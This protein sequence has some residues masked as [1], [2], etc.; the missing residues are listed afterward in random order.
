MESIIVP[1][2]RNLFRLY[3]QRNLSADK[4]DLLSD[5]SIFRAIQPSWKLPIAALKTS[6]MEIEIDG[7][8]NTGMQI[9][10]L[11]LN[12]NL[13]ST[14]S[15]VIKR[16]IKLSVFTNT[17][18]NSVIRILENDKYQSTFNQYRSLIQFNLRRS[19][20]WQ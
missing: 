8:R 9:P 16:P 13:P 3:G 15:R 17:G 18:D 4:F 5:V 14:D 7:A 6:E 19:G 12:R 2:R 10:N 11:V 1:L 20:T